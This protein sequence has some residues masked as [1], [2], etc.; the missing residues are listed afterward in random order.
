MTTLSVGE[1]L[2]SSPLKF[3]RMVFVLKNE[4]E[5]LEFNRKHGVNPL[6]HIYAT[7][8]TILTLAMGVAIL[9]VVLW[10]CS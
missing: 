4:R 6:E 2:V 8:G 3:L 10:L 9:G 1:E 7:Q 5:F